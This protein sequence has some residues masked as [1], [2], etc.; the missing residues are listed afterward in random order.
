VLVKASSPIKKY[1]SGNPASTSMTLHSFEHCQAMISFVLPHG[2]QV[3]HQPNE[4]FKN[5]NRFGGKKVQ[6]SAPKIHK[7]M[8]KQLQ[9]GAGEKATV[10]LAKKGE[11]QVLHRSHEKAKEMCSRGI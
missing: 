10:P 2:W 7:N 3:Y 9:A 1:L 4:T 11:S 6:K 8:N 5:K